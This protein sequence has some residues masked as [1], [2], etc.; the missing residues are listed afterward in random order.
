MNYFLIIIIIIII[1]SNKIFLHGDYKH[2]YKYVY[3]Y[4]QLETENKQIINI[5]FLNNMFMI[6][7]INIV[8]YVYDYYHRYT[9]S[10]CQNTWTIGEWKMSLEIYLQWCS[11]RQTVPDI[12]GIIVVNFQF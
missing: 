5:L 9:F 12:K 1:Q 6:I 11:L 7:I 10:Q 4:D 8:K 3:G 2:I